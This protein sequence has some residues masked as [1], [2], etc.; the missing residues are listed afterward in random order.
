MITINAQPPLFNYS[1][2]PIVVKATTDKYY[3]EP[4]TF[5][6]LELG[7]GGLPEDYIGTTF[8]IT[9][10]LFKQ[11]FTFDPSKGNTATNTVFPESITTAV[12]ASDY[13]AERL[14]QNY[15][16]N[17]YY[18][19]T[20]GFNYGNELQ[21][22]T[23]KK[24]G[25][26]YTTTTIVSAVGGFGLDYAGTDSI[27]SG[28]SILIQ[29]LQYDSAVSVNQNAKVI[30]FRT[31]YPDV[32]GVIEEDVSDIINDFL[33]YEFNLAD[34]TLP[35]LI[36]KSNNRYYISVSEL[37]VEV[38]A[39]DS[40]NEIGVLNTT[41]DFYTLKGGVDKKTFI[42]PS[43]DLTNAL[44]TKTKTILTDYPGNIPLYLDKPSIIY[45][46]YAG[47]ARVSYLRINAT[48]EDGSIYE[49][50]GGL[51]LTEPADGIVYQIP[52]LVDS[53][54]YN[55]AETTE[56]K[57]IANI[58]A[59][60]FD[61]AAQLAGQFYFEVD[62]KY[63]KNFNTLF[64]KNSKGA[65]EQVYCKGES[66]TSVEIEFEVLNKT[67]PALYSSSDFQQARTELD[68]KTPVII[69]TGHLK[70]RAVKKWMA[71]LLIHGEGYHLVDG[72]LIPII[73]TNNKLSVHDT[74]ED[75]YSYDIE[76]MYSYT[77]NSYQS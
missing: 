55:A 77:D 59:Q 13:F 50:I 26:D 4:G 33:T 32:N 63:Y 43:Y 14:R 52:V 36:S 18:N 29:V 30:G 45:F 23:A 62:K 44:V 2:N 64:L 24:T 58:F 34:L 25:A 73:I 39:D 41:D 69:N 46:V 60:V 10:N 31:V 75:T 17:K 49:N 35:Y 9:T 27:P 66:K 7:I 3:V 1:K 65:L 53:A 15:F 21:I 54:F 20:R 74:N 37:G 8:E 71:D 47:A 51:F 38:A 6:K 67:L 40:V 22:L 68:F 70:S 42:N 19:V 28:V 48:F 56:G 12:A 16:I 11:K 5:A 76:F 72:Q 61:S 57:K